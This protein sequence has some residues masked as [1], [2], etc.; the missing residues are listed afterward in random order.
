MS[1]RRTVQ[2]L[3]L[4]ALVVAVCLAAAEPQ[5]APASAQADA[6]T[7]S[8]AK[9]LSLTQPMPVDPQITV[10][11]FSNGLRY[12][13][14]TNKLPEKRAEL[15]LAVNAGSV[16]EDNDQL[17]LA[18]MVEHMAFNGTE[19]FAKQ[20]IV[21]FM[22]SIGMRFG[23]SL[24]AFTS[25]DE[26]VYMLTI[27]TDK[28][29]VME[30]AFLIL[31]DWAQNL[32]FDAT[33]IDKERGVIVEEWRLGRGASARMRDKQ[34]PILF[35]G[36][37]YA[38][39]L[40]IG[41]KESIETFKHDALKRFYKDWYRPDLMAVVA[42]GDFDK[43]AVESLI[44]QHFSSIPA[45]KVPRLRPMYNVPDH[46]DTLYTIATDKEAPMT[47]I[48]VYN[49]L[50]LQEQGSVDVYR[51]KIVD[52]LAAGMLSRRLSDLTQKPDAP[53][54]S[55]AAGLSIFVRTKEAAM[56]NA[57]PKEGSI[58]RAL[59]ALLI[60]ASRVARFGFTPT[61]LD[62]QKI[63]RLRTYERYLAEKD[64]HDSAVLAGEL[65]RNFTDKE[66]LPG[67]ALEYALHQ[68]FLPEITLDEVNKIGKKWTG[69]ASRIVVVSAPEKA[70]IVVPDEVRL[71]A[72][73]KGVGTKEITAY[74]DTVANAV[75]LDKVPEP[76][77]IVKT[78]NKE[79]FGITEWNLSNGVKVVLKPTN[80]KQD[81]I[82][83]RATSPGGTSLAT[84]ED[85]IPARTASQAMA[86]SGLGKFST[87]DLR[88]VL[89]GKIAA[90]SALIG[91]LEEGLSGSC[92][93]KDLETMFQLIYLRFTEPRTD[94]SAFAANKAQG[95]AVLANQQA[96]PAWAFSE[97]LQSTLTQNHPR[98][99]PMTVET[100]DQMNLEKSLAFYKDR[101]ADASDFT[102]VFVGTFDIETMKPFVERYLASLPALHRNETWKDVGIRPPKGMVEK[103]V[104]KG[105]EPQS[106][107]AIVFGGPFQY[108]RDHRVA[109]RALGMV[110]DTK[111]REVLRE[112]LSGTYGVSVSPGYTVIPRQEYSFM[113]Q[114]GC[115]PQRTEDLVKVIFQEIENLKKNGPSE[116]QVSDV[117]E[118]MLREFETNT[119]QNSYLLG[120]IYLRYQVPQDLG[121][122][123]GLAEYYKTLNAKMILD[124]A[125]TYLNIDNYVKVTL[126][127]ESKAETHPVEKQRD[128]A[129][130]RRHRPA[131]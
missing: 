29:E 78:T 22:E 20:Q 113:I 39:R 114:F 99:R 26:T 107:A 55:A 126:L 10:G 40:P 62:R 131:A 89:A 120:Q 74:V 95:K 25:F 9:A 104:K 67:P 103:V 19:H 57:I 5:V 102:F 48:S 69:D 27:P 118:A 23:P 108:D 75:L 56:L 64:K 52:R 77:K 97:T 60:E 18:H 30:K 58:D 124:A 33:E 93:P 16:L 66:T 72:A 119:K 28:P 130:G 86:V 92:S 98:A 49:K 21:N 129:P 116:K 43:S 31:E 127:P 73:V 36:A 81:E 105:I 94:Q 111:L 14:R 106:Q 7:Q 17:G 79:A 117:R 128:D 35:K 82:V 63:E 115:N 32:S 54:V 91:E 1:L 50:P 13:I 38:D 70:G 12:Y 46:P 109:I 65:V 42:V 76:G 84:D 80:Y 51:Q 125:R 44:K 2:Q 68:R 121:E 53:F 90:V 15:R 88:K 101:F 11:R 123:F 100:I 96:T 87:V 59:E 6:Q 71:A 8:Q 110:L 85:Y 112:D 34:F 41:T 3:L 47:S 4:F 61:E 37:R 83:F 122:F 24:N 45:V